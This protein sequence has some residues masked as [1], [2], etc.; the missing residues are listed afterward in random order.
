VDGGARSYDLGRSVRNALALLSLGAAGIHFAFIGVHLAEDWAHGAFFAIVAWAQLAWAAAIVLRPSRPLLRA[1]ALGSGA[2]IATWVVSRTMGVPV[3]PDAGSPEPVALY[4]SLA[5][6]FELGIVAGSLALLTLPSLARRQVRSVVTA[7]LLGALGLAVGA[8]STVALSPTFAAGHHHGTRTAA[9]SHHEGDGHQNDGHHHDGDASS[10][11]HGDQHAEGHGDDAAAHGHDGGST[12][13]ARD[14]DGDQHPAGDD[15]A[16]TGHAGPGAAATDDGGHGHLSAPLDVAGHG[17]TSPPAGGPASGHHA[18]PPPGLPPSDHHAPPPA[19][20]S[21]GP[22]A[23]APAP[24]HDHGPAPGGPLTPAQ[25]AAADKLV[26]DTKAG[27][28]RYA[29]L[30]AAIADGYTELTPPGRP[31]VH[32]ANHDYMHDG[33]ILDPERVE[34]LVYAFPPG[35]APV[36]LGAMYMMEKAGGPGPLIGGSLTQW[37]VHDN[38]CIDPVREIN[39]ARQPNGSCPPGSAVIVTPEMLHVWVIDYPTG[40]F[41][42]LDAPGAQAAILRTIGAAA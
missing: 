41:G 7:P 32:Y 3:G 2:V 17:H 34:S 4:D 10:A 27:L 35:H 36:L 20:P 12:A 24:G 5:T 33:R 11:A 38:L 6:V 42:E 26:A 9:H 1:G 14:H 16:G 28:A 23:A 31:I 19:A 30:D 29:S 21:G 22:P 8:L 13:A 18:P 40:P 15:H 39:V 25:Q 37:H